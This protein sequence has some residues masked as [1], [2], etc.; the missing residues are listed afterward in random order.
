MKIYNTK[1][2]KLTSELLDL[3][4]VFKQKRNFKPEDYVLAKAM[5]LND[6][7][8]KHSLSSC[9]VGVSGGIDSAVVL[10]I[11]HQASKQPRSP[12]KKIVPILL[13]LTR[14]QG[15]T[16]QKEATKR[17]VEVCEAFKLKPHTVDLSKVETQMINGVDEEVGISGKPWAV[18]QLVSYLR[19]PALYYTAALLNQAGKPAIV[20]GTTNQDEGA[21]LG[22]F[23]KASDGLVDVQVISDLHKSE[24]FKVGEFLKVPQSILEVEPS[25]DM[26]D[27][28]SDEEVFGASYDFV[29]LYLNYLKMST[30]EQDEFKKHL[31]EDSLK[32]F[33]QGQKNLEKMHSYNKHKYLGASPAVHL[34]ILSGNVPGGWKNNKTIS[35]ST[36]VKNNFVNLIPFSDTISKK[37]LK[38]HPATQAVGNNPLLIE[39]LLTQKEVELLLNEV[40]QHQWSAVGVNGYLKDYK[41]GDVVGSYRL[42]VFNEELAQVLWSRIREFLPAFRIMKDEDKTDFHPHPVWTPVGINPLFRFIKYLE[43]GSLVPHYDAPFE[44][45]SEKK[46]LMSLII[47]LTTNESGAT[48]FI[49]DPQDAK[50]FTLRVF[51]DWKH[52]AHNHD[53]K[54]EHLPQA[55]NAMIF[56]HRHLHDADTLNSGEIKILIRTDIVFEKG[57]D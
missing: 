6:Y 28:R 11:I 37:M 44:Y 40:N 55:G 18:G 57:G 20:C 48:R 33:I 21:Y 23:G 32:Q 10:G 5:V 31:E 47:Y 42:S 22:Y 49:K 27:G 24:V 19:T 15:A 14:S 2:S 51:A 17:G 4:A 46:T 35:K 34:D 43:N 3:L 26:Y 53:V 30:N 16:N 52:P 54:S 9:I 56:D 8:K 12:I 38:M 25:G 45:H 41:E 36:A 7:M 29:E 13:P 1:T 39:R 50:D